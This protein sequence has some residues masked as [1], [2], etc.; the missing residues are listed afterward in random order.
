MKFL[1][2][3]EDTPQGIQAGGTAENNGCTDHSATS[4]SSMIAAR[5]YLLLTESPLALRVEEV[6]YHE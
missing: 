2:C 1:L 4:L 5:I 3:I 6:T